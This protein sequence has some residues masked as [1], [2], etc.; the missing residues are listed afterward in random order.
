V[1]QN[2]QDPGTAYGDALAIVTVT[3]SPGEML[4]QLLASVPAAT[5]TDPIV[6]LS[7]NGS[8]DGTIEP[9]LKR[10]PFARAAYNGDNLGYGRAVN[11]ATAGLPEDIGWILVVNPD[12]RLAPGSVDELLRVIRSDDGIGAV[13]PLIVSEHGVPYPS[14]RQLPSLRTGILHAVLAGVWPGNPW[15][16]RYRQDDVVARGEQVTTGWL[17]GACV[18][19]RRT[20]FEQVGGFDDRFFMYFEDVDLGK[21]LGDAGWK[22]VYVPSAKVMHVGATTASR[23][24]SRTQRA[25]HESAYLY[26]AKKY[27]QWWLAPVRWAIKAGL[28]V[29]LWSIMRHVEE[30]DED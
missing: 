11:A 19:V 25:H 10:Y 15:S 30:S 17:S 24:P 23:F 29:R 2:R 6:V 4:E 5:A 21:Q 1:P 16:T 20:A 9:A 8:T 26:M 13:G 7:D 18:L 27:P 22:N 12:S 3:Y 28:A 14:A